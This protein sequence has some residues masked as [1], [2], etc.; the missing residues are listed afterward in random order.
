MSGRPERPRTLWRHALLAY[1]VVLTTAT[2]WPNLRIEGVVIERP[3][4]LL[5]ASAF[6]V[7]TALII[8]GR[9]FGEALSMRNVSLSVLVG[10][11]WAGLDEVTQG[12]PFLNRYVAWSDF[13]ANVVGVVLVGALSAGWCWK[14][15]RSAA[16]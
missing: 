3:D 9:F 4:L 5:H 12:L 10:L 13:L 15:A 16:R 2:H 14:K 11:A 6:G 8:A 1:G 7:L